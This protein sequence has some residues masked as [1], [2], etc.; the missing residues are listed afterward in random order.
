MKYCFGDIVIVDENQIGVIVK[1]WE[2]SI[3]GN[4]PNHDVYVR[5]YNGIKNY[6]ESEIRRYMV[7]HKYLDEQEMEWQ[8]NADGGPV[9]EE[10][11]EKWKVDIMQD[12]MLGIMRVYARCPKCGGVIRWDPPF[13][14]RANMDQEIYRWLPSTCN[15]CNTEMSGFELR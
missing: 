9:K 12:R 13:D 2:G 15:R 5:S 14:A 1:S 10:E 4:G 8:A 3:Q 7:R 11:K 6:P